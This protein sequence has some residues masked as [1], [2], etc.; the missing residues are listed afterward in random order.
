MDIPK[1]LRRF[2]VGFCSTVAIATGLA[3]GV[4]GQ[5][6]PAAKT[7]RLYVF[8]CGILMGQN[9]ATYNLTTTAAPKGDMS[10]ACFLVVHPRGTLIWDTGGVPDARVTTG[11]S[12]DIDLELTPGRKIPWRV[13]K[14][15]RDQLREVGYQPSDI[16]YLALSHM[17]YDHTANAND[18]H[19][20]TWLVQEVERDRMF[21][22][23]PP[24]SFST[25]SDLKSSKTTLLHG[26][27]DVF[28]DGTV[29][30]KSTPGHTAGHQSLFVNLAGNGPLLLSGDLY[31]YPEERA[32]KV[33]PTF[34]FNKEQSLASRAAIEE[35][36][37]QRGAQL[38][39]QHDLVQN[40]KLKKSPQFYE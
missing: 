36:M 28:G 33:V 31:H 13:D 8:D 25:Y 24:S 35:F 18:F 29:V 1:R 38:W 34:E 5:Q 23:S 10:V 21:G 19:S 39:I 7:V 17:H 4:S 2:L 30:I 3:L 37:Q 27:Y 16:T 20:A 40:E 11:R 26:D 9:I 6:P 32:L 12:T 15:L 22:T 14:K